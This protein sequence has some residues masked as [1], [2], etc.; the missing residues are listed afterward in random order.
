MNKKTIEILKGEKWW[1]GLIDVAEK[2]P[3]DQ[4]TAFFADI[5]H[6]TSYNQ[7]NPLLISDAGRYIWCE[8]YFSLNISGG[9]IQIESPGEIVFKDGFGDLKSAYLDL[10]K[11]YFPFNGEIPKEL[12]FSKPQYC[13]WI[14]LL[15]E[16]TEENILNYA[17]SI[18]DAGYP[19]GELIIDAGWQYDYGEWNFSNGKIKNP[20][21]MVEELKKMGFETILWIVPYIS[22]DSATFRYAES[23]GYLQKNAEGESLIVHWWDGYS[24]SVDLSNPAAAEW[25]NGTLK[26][27]IGQYGFAGFK[28]DG[29]DA[30]IY[31]DQAVG[32]IKLTANEQSELYA[33][34]ALNFPVSEIR[35]CCKCGGLPLAQRIADRRHNWGAESGL[36]GLIPKVIAQGISGY[37][38]LCADMIGGGQFEDFL[39]KSSD[40]LDE[41]LMLRYLECVALMPMMQ[42]SYPIW[43][44]FGESAKNIGKKFA[45][46]HVEYSQKIIALAK[47]ASN[48]GEPI[49]RGM[50]FDYGIKGVTD[51]FMIGKDL[52]VAPVVTKG[53]TERK[54]ILPEGKW[55]YVP[56]GAVYE[57]GVITVS[58]PIDVLPFFEKI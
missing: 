21:K 25:F 38:Y 27:L 57:G 22:P 18:I 8:E 48:T 52:L 53:Q 46:L 13:T 12:L 14:A 11:N 32:Y 37:P 54:V 55:K 51:Q 43:T 45:D 39:Q 50:D 23:K 31:L 15:Y 4:T 24:A 30:R 44:N 19:A 17:R 16:Q 47:N 9:V 34:N 5:R 41:E 42:F 49:L 40:S 20:K 36:A 29:G 35:A 56:T 28:F 58:A 33:E 7:C 6:D 26:D 2:M 10:S 1:G 3:F